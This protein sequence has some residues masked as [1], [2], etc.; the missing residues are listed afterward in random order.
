MITSFTL[1]TVKVWKGE[2]YFVTHGNYKHV[3]GELTN[4][5]IMAVRYKTL[6]SA[7][8]CLKRIKKTFDVADIVELNVSVGKTID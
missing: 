3:L 1:Y 5:P 4:D 7:K 8:S 2:T 6:K